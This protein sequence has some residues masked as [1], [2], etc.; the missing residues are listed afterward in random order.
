MLLSSSPAST[1]NE[2]KSKSISNEKINQKI[3]FEE[4]K[5]DQKF[6][7]EKISR[8][9]RFRNFSLDERKRIIKKIRDIIENNFRIEIALL[10]DDEFII[11]KHDENF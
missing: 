5:N 7:I 10:I 9:F 1:K 11:I 8:S 6:D 2:Q 4:Q 3:D